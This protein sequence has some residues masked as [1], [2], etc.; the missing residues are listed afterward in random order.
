MFPLCIWYIPANSHKP[1]F[2]GYATVEEH[3]HTNNKYRLTSAAEYR[4]YGDR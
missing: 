2:D 1:D 4:S 3:T